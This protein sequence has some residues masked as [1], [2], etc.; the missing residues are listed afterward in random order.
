MKPQ[1]RCSHAL[2]GP[3]RSLV[4]T[5]GGLHRAG[6]HLV[7]LAIGADEDVESTMEA[8]LLRAEHADPPCLACLAAFQCHHG[9]VTPPSAFPARH[10]SGENSRHEFV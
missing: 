5:S 10:R 6:G 7:W 3:A 1:V 4:P 2:T 9:L 8:R